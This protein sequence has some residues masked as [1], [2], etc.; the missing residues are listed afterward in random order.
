MLAT[1]PYAE[2]VGV[3][4]SLNKMS[5]F[6]KGLGSR[7][8]LFRHRKGYRLSNS[9]SHTDRQKHIWEARS[10]MGSAIHV[11]HI[12]GCDP[13]IL[14]GVDGRRINDYRYFWQMPQ[15]RG[16]VPYR[17]D[18]VK[19]DTFRRCII[20]QIPA[21]TD[22]KSINHYWEKILQKS[23]LNIYNASPISLIRSIPYVNFADAICLKH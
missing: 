18:S 11:A 20:D 15:W 22:L 3:F 19:I 23:G 17:N 7:A 13:I 14:L 4:R 1:I 12:M 5:T 6:T 21:D 9:Y 8:V 16:K 10:S 2:D